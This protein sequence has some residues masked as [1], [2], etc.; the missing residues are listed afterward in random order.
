MLP[1]LKTLQEHP[2]PF[3]PEVEDGLS[4][5]AAGCA[6]PRGSHQAGQTWF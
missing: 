2:V 1:S 4:L 5:R 3:A 6:P